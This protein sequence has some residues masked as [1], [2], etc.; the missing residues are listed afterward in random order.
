[1]QARDILT[2]Y[3]NSQNQSEAALVEFVQKITDAAMTKES[4]AT[5]RMN[6]L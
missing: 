5:M 3:L 1:M 2:C 6:N 4:L